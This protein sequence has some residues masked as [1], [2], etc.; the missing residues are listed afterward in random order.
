MS[1]FAHPVLGIAIGYIFYKS[2]NHSER[3]FTFRLFLIF[4]LG[5]ILPDIITM[6]KWSIMF[7]EIPSSDILEYLNMFQG[8]YHSVFGWLFFAFI[9]AIIFY[10]SINIRGNNKISFLRCYSILVA[11][12]WIHF[13]QDV[14]IQSISIFPP[15]RYSLSDIFTNF[16]RFGREEDVGVLIFFIIFLIIPLIL[17]FISFEKIKSNIEM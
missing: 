10:I 14:M 8:Y 7:T 12:G 15:I 1:V 16:P 3:R 6:I 13:G 11:S 5:S 9:Y 17:L 4:F 2:T